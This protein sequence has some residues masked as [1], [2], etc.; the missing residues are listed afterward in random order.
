MAK[1]RDSHKASEIIASQYM[2]RDERRDRIKAAAEKR[3]AQQL[4]NQIKPTEES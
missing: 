1:K 2:K 4:Q 3:K